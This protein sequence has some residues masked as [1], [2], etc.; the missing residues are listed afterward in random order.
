MENKKKVASLFVKKKCVRVCVQKQV[1]L[2]IIQ[3]MIDKKKETK[4][5]EN[6]MCLHTKT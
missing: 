4:R 3:E 1:Q 6:G 5:L 2:K